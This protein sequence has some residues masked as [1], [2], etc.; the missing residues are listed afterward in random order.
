[1]ARRWRTRFADVR[2][3]RAEP[4][5]PGGTPWRQATY[6]VVDLELTGLDPRHDS[7]ISFGA[8]PVEGGRV[9]VRD[10]RC[11]LCRPRTPLRPE[12]IVIHGLRRVDLADAPE[13]EAAL[14]PLLDAMS[15]RILV[16]HSSWVE[17]AFLRRAFRHLGVRL[18]GPII[19]T[20]RL[21]T[22]LGSRMG[23]SLGEDL[24]ELA[25]SLGLPEH[26]AHDALGDALTTAQVFI[27]LAT[28]LDRGTPETVATLADV[29]KRKASV[30]P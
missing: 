9:V 26:R 27:A 7:I 25:S 8:V 4:A 11:G 18:R 14:R 23:R 28:L 10:S 19:D 20:Q 30:T 6:C 1:M 16:A 24:S 2:R 12:S 17:E 15:G 29:G 5:A 13:P 21:G 22:V 3:Y